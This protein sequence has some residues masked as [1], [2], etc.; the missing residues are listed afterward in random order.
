M[1]VISI[2]YTHY[3]FG[4]SGLIGLLLLK[5]VDF[6]TFLIASVIIDIEGIS[7]LV[8]KLSYPLHGYF[9]SFL[10]AFLAALL[11]ILVMKFLR[12]YFSPIMAVFK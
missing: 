3:H 8:F 9:H 2:P 5:W 11:L 10:G 7:V 6:P 4:P 12:K 1:D